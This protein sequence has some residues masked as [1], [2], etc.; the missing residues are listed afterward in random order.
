M[1]EAHMT[2]AYMRSQS[3]PKLKVLV[4]VGKTV[5]TT[6]YSRTLLVF[7]HIMSIYFMYAV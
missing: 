5:F 4:S 6:A 1:E 7:C 2:R 3:G